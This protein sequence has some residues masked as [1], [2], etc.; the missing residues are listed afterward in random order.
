M[1]YYMLRANVIS[2]K[3]QSVVASASYR[4]GM[5]LYSERDQEIKNFRTRGVAPV[6]FILSPD[7]APKWTH[8]REKLWNEVE[9]KEKAWNAQLAREILIALPLEL[10]HDQQNKLVKTFVQTNFVDEGMVADVAIHRDKEHNPHAHVLLTVRPFNKDGS[11]GEKKRRAYERDENGEIKRTE[12]GKKI[13]QTVNSTDWNHRETLVKWRLAYADMMNDAFLENDIQQKVSALSF[14]DQGL[15]KIAEV[16]LERNEYQFVKRLEAQGKEATTFYHQLNQQIRKTNEQITK[17]NSKIISL[18]A[19][20]STPS[21]EKILHEETSLVMSQLEP[22][23]QKSIQFLQGRLKQE[24]TFGN[25]RQ[26]LDGLYR[27]RERTAE[28]NEAKMTVT[29]SL[30]DAANKAYHGQNKEFLQL[31]GFSMNNFYEQFIPRLETYEEAEHERE[32]STKTQDMLI[33]HTERVYNVFSLVTHRTFNQIYPDIPEKF[34]WNDRV[35]LIKNELLGALKENKIDQL[36]HPEEVSDVLSIA[37]IYKLLE[38]SDSISNTIRI[39]SL[40]RNKLGIEKDALIKNR[41]ELDKIYHLSIK[42]N[43]MQQL[44]VQ[45]SRKAELV[46]KQ[47]E[48]LLHKLF[49]DEKDSV[50]TRLDSMPLQVKADI[51]RFYKDELKKGYVPSLRTCVRFAKDHEAKRNIQQQVYEKNESSPFFKRLSTTQKDIT[52]FIGGRAS[53]ELLEQLIHQSSS[54]QSSKQVDQT[55]LK[56]RRKTKDQRIRQQLDLEVDL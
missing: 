7:H 28:P 27:W 55:P 1:S 47:L 22:E 41:R 10:D 17:L 29:H 23:Y 15:E 30:L 38:K 48:G 33:E 37:E 42:L 54:T 36:I 3:T 16:R 24:V 5:S 19:H 13:F 40:T 4:S 34:K 18:A 21:V 25:V 39:Q 43:T 35:L 45:S 6:S 56:M 49:Y 2:K 51:L 20:Q 26:H 14:E 12:Y 11:W 31:Q 50:L 32:K 46:N 53:G 9:K 52:H 44:L 8:D